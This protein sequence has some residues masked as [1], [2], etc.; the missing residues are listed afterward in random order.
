ML[1][2]A[3]IAE[4]LTDGSPLTYINAVALRYPRSDLPVYITEVRIRGLEL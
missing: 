2:P 1:V 3:K 4:R